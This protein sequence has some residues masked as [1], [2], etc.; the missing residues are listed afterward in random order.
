MVPLSR[1]RASTG[2]RIDEN[3]LH[4][5]IFRSTEAHSGDGKLLGAQMLS[6]SGYFS[7]HCHIRP[8]LAV[9]VCARGQFLLPSLVGCWYI[10]GCIETTISE[11]GRARRRHGHGSILNPTN[12]PVRPAADLSASPQHS[13]LDRLAK[14]EQ[15][16]DGA[17]A[18]EEGEEET[19]RLIERNQLRRARLRTTALIYQRLQRGRSRHSAGTLK[20]SVQDCTSSD[21]TL[22]VAYEAAAVAAESQSDADGPI[23]PADRSMWLKVNSLVAYC[24]FFVIDLEIELVFAT[25][26]HLLLG[27]DGHSDQPGIQVRPYKGV[28]AIT[29]LEQGVASPATYVFGPV[30]EYLQN[31]GYSD[32][33]LR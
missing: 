29:Y 9:H 22:I 13:E 2:V 33:N 18:V 5:S 3:F 26:Q 25:L 1:A 32:K 21:D 8:Y 12:F 28:S 7:I 15:N 16:Q 6:I 14:D 20:V 31:H 17:A 19:N 11:K 23:S 27:R 30:V 24:V 10:V 4:I